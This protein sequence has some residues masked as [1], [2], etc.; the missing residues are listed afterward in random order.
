VCVCHRCR[1]CGSCGFVLGWSSQSFCGI[2]GICVQLFVDSVWF[3]VT[4]TVQHLSVWHSP[5][6]ALCKYCH[7]ALIDVT[8]SFQAEK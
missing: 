8:C 7:A 5:L 6:H 2:L 4:A 1:L 3:A